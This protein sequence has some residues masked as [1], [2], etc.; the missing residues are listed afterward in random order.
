MLQKNFRTYFQ[1]LLHARGGKIRGE[2]EEKLSYLTDYGLTQEDEHMIMISPLINYKHS[3]NSKIWVRCTIPT[4]YPH[5][6]LVTSKEQP[7]CL[8]RLGIQ[9]TLNF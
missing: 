5:I 2:W 4:R 8:Y 3:K 9:K 6:S 7:P 1:K